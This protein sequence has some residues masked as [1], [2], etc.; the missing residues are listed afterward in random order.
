MLVT[1]KSILVTFS[2][3]LKNMYRV[4][5]KAQSSLMYIVLAEV[6]QADALPSCFSSHSINNRPFPGPLTSTFL[7]FFGDFAV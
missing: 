1:P 7:L 2:W 4:G 3:S 5:K 6:Q